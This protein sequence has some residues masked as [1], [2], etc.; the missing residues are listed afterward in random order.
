MTFALSSPSYF[1]YQSIS[2]VDKMSQCN[3]DIEV[4]KSFLMFKD[5]DF[6]LNVLKPRRKLDTKIYIIEDI[7]CRYSAIIV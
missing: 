3:I 4:G 1:S 6:C 5:E 7:T 2:Y